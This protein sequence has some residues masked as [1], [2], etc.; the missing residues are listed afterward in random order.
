MCVH[1][2]FIQF[3][4]TVM[5]FH[6]TVNNFTKKVFKTF[7]LSTNNIKMMILVDVFFEKY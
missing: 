1:D 5:A 6:S 3:Y 7:V 2:V 4:A